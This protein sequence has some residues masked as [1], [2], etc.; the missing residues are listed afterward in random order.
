MIPLN[1]ALF[2]RKSSI[3]SEKSNT[4][5]MRIIRVIAPK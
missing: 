1:G 2:S 4:T 5:A 3:F